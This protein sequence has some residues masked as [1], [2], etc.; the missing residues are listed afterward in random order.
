M[1]DSVIAGFDDHAAADAAVK[2]LSATGFDMKSLSVVGKGY[3]TE[4]KVVG[5]YNTG[6]RIEFWGK[7]G[8]MW[9]GLWGL[10]FGG[11]FQA[12]PVLDHVVFLVSREDQ[13]EP[14]LACSP[15]P[16][17]PNLREAVARVLWLA[18]L[19]MVTVPRDPAM[20]SYGVGGFALAG[21]AISV[22]AL[23]AGLAIPTCP[24]IASPTVQTFGPGK[25]NC[26]PLIGTQMDCLL[27]AGRIAP[28]NRNVAAFGLDLLPPGDQA[29]FR[30]WCLAA[31]DDC[32]VTVTGR[33]ASPQSTRLST[34][35]SMHWTRPSAPLDEAAARAVEKTSSTDTAGPANRVQ[36]QRALYRRAKFNHAACPGR[37]DASMETA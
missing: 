29:L 17:R 10:F 13:G 14:A 20:R 22:V 12:I 36:A 5:F 2:Q 15:R 8:A 11:L 7:R 19:R 18:R 27:A 6:D 9:G 32:S 4:E 33:R 3:H 37:N 25:V 28:D 21:A 30:K 34:V 35:T 1:E 26:Q 31:G 16:T 24:A 23:L